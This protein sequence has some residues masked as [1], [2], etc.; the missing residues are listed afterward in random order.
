MV[1][2]HAAGLARSYCEVDVAAY[3]AMGSPWTIAGGKRLYEVIP[4]T[5]LTQLYLEGDSLVVVADERWSFS[6][7]KA[8]LGD[9]RKEKLLYA[10]AMRRLTAA[11]K[12]LS[13]VYS[14]QANAR[15]CQATLNLLAA[16]AKYGEASLLL[17]GVTPHP[18]HLV[19]QMRSVASLNPVATVVDFDQFTE[20]AV[21][22]RM[23]KLTAGL[24]EGE[25]LVLRQKVTGLL[26]DLR[27]FDAMVYLDWVLSDRFGAKDPRLE[28]LSSN[29]RT[30]LDER[31]LKERADLLLK[32]VRK[33]AAQQRIIEDK[34]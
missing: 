20:T 5:S 27:P 6:S 24:G 34:G 26:K 17:K 10:A 33:A 25:A 21:L 8:S 9:R 16:A 14:S 15:P 13:I 32:H 12:H 28:L 3:P 22:R 23:E 11:I 2:C 31:E 30:K 29:I 18:S 7:L 4:I 19:E 1:G